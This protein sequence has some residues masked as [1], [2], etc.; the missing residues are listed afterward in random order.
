MEWIMTTSYRIPAAFRLSGLVTLMMLLV[1][2]QKNTSFALALAVPFSLIAYALYFSLGSTTIAS[3]VRQWCQGK[4][5]RYLAL[6]LLLVALLYLY[7]A[8]GGGKPFTGNSWR[9]PLLFCAPVLF[10][11]WMIGSNAAIT[12]KDAVGAVLCILPYVLHDYPFDSKLPF[13]GGGI[14]TLYLTLA[15]IVAVYSVVVVRQMDRVGFV[16][17]ASLD[18]LKITLKGWAIFFVLVM[19][20]G[21]PSGIMKWVGHDPIT[22]AVLISG[23]ALFLRTFFGTALP[24]ELIFRG[25]FL[26]LLQQ[27]IKQTG[28]WRRYL[29]GAVLLLPLAAVA[30]Y[31]T[32]DKTQWFPLLCAAL[33]WAF[34]FWL[35]RRDAEQT[36]AYT[37]L[38][39]V[40]TLFGLAHY[41]VHSTIF[42]GLAMAAGWTYG[43]VYYKTGSVFY[44]ALC[45]TLV[46]VAPALFGF[47]LVR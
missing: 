32:E 38:L 41:H 3:D 28:N 31:T 46:N 39:I 14:E 34:T 9:I 22:P 26:N 12:W 36:S 5:L 11:R 29:Y 27:R 18:A 44:S 47:A 15:I 45:H 40:S 2:W 17:F 7:V 8:L 20:I 24:E 43:H 13:G 30:G 16:P 10:Y 37:A 4:L 42:M 21:L 6:P 19:A 1:A 35:N 25:L 33:L 23:L